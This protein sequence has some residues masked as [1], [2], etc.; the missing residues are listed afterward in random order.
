MKIL[1][2]LHNDDPV[3]SLLGEMPL[4]SR[5]NDEPAQVPSK[6]HRL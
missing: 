2:F 5:E 3:E 1:L 4:L 6:S